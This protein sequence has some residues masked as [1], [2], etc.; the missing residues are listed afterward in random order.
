MPDE[1]T[2]NPVP[3]PENATPEKEELDAGGKTEPLE[4]TLDDSRE[5][6]VDALEQPGAL[7]VE[8]MAESDEL[9]RRRR[10]T[11]NRLQ[12]S[13]EVG[14]SVPLEDRGIFEEN[15][16]L[17][18]ILKEANLSPRHLRFCCSGILLFL[19]LILLGFGGIQTFRYFNNK[20]PREKIEKPPVEEVQEESPVVELPEVDSLDVSL[21]VG[22]LVGNPAQVLDPA[23]ETGQDLGEVLLSDEILAERIVDLGKMVQIMEVGVVEL[24]DQSRDRQARFDE[25]NNEL[26][27]LLYLGRQNLAKLEKEKEMYEQKINSTEAQ[28]NTLEERFFEKLKSLDAYGSTAALND[29]V[30]E[31]ESLASL[32]AQYQARLNLIFYYEAYLNDMELRVLDLELNEEALVKGVKVVNVHGSDLDLIIDETEL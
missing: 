6:V 31:A 22:V 21:Q 17:M 20:P 16:G 26:K 29:F 9:M 1:T 19:L 14:E 11:K 18:E 30:V 12:A 25:Y 24:L 15:A 7:E 2:V 4:E 8:E 3:K 27:F 28:K 10:S 23:L 13:V 5:T 32:R